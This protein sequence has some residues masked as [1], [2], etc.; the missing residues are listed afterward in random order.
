[1][2]VTEKSK[3]AKTGLM[4][5]TYAPQSTC[6][7]DCPFLNNGCYGEYGPLRFRN[8][9]ADRGLDR[10]QTATLEAELISGLPGKY[11]LR[12]HVVGDCATEK[13]A[14]IVGRAMVEYEDRTGQP[15]WAY[16]HSWEFIDRGAW[17]GAM[18]RA[19]CES[20]EQCDR[21]RDK[22]YWPVL[23]TDS[24][25]VLQCWQEVF[26]IQCVECLL[27]R[28]AEDTIGFTPH[29][30]GKKKVRRVLDELQCN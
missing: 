3:N 15:A 5:C 20:E 8:V 18:V 19:S 13:T 10:V 26:G 12:V 16:T 21:A 1:M 9:G 14:A 29:G 28:W 23:V 7:D 6:P 30:S 17:Q 4:S 25:K 27:C 11:P 24:V 2:I 22:E